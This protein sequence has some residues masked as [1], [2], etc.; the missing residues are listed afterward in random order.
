MEWWWTAFTSTGLER[1][2]GTYESTR[3]W[4][5]EIIDEVDDS[6]DNNNNNNNNNN[7]DT[8]NEGASTSR[9]SDNDDDE[10][11]FSVFEK[12]SE[13]LDHGPLTIIILFR[14]NPRG[15]DFFCRIVF[16][17]RCLVTKKSSQEKRLPVREKTDDQ[18]L[19]SIKLY[20]SKKNMN[21]CIQLQQKRLKS[22]ESLQKTTYD[23]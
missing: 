11:Y 17:N 21:I 6:N 13:V 15:I 8:V 22:S 3:S 23:F 10:R 20:Y 1:S 19:P 16:Y 5:K 7:N 18:W 4:G 14:G 9:Q 2:V 12:V